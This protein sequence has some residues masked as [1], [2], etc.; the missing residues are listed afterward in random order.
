MNGIHI[1]KFLNENGL[2]KRDVWE[3]KKKGK[4]FTSRTI[5]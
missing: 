1:Q 4:L 5:N 3:I 2:D